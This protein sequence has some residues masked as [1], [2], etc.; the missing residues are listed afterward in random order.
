[1]TRMLHIIQN[2]PEVP[3][4]N[5]VEG[6]TIPYVVHHPYRGDLIPAVGDMA[7]LLV[8]GGA[9]GALDDGKY[10]FLA[11]VKARI[12]D[13]VA[14]DV[15]YLGICLGGQ[16]LAAALGAPVVSRRWEELGM[17]DV[18]LTREGRGDRLF[19]GI[20]ETFR[21]FQ[22]HNDSFDIPDGGTVLA[23]SD[24][25]P[26]QAFRVGSAWGVQFHPEVT[27]RIIRSWCA[28]SHKTSLRTE[29]LRAA[30]SREAAVYNA[31]SRQILHNFLLAANLLKR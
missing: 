17:L 2:D 14:A 21:T 7:A 19:E 15:P 3:P 22:W 8:L 23:Y 9:M 18:S 29:E 24:A 20:P 12:R 16:L 13:V 11:D 5:L 6:L 30:F 10:P 1:M 31:T 26:H 27:E 4:G 28:W 25:C